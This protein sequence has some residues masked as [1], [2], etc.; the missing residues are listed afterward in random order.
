[1]AKKW[2]A[3]HKKN[4]NVVFLN[5]EEKEAY[6]KDVLTAKAYR[7]ELNEEA[8]EEVKVAPPVDAKKAKQSTKNNDGN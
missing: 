8:I 7:F 1:M 4:G 3:I 2:K 6:E 5:Q